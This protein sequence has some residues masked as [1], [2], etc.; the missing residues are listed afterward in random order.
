MIYTKVE[1][2]EIY[3]C[4]KAVSGNKAD[5][6]KRP[7]IVVSGDQLNN[8]YSSQCMV[9]C[10]TTVP[11]K[12]RKSHVPLTSTEAGRFRGSTV[13][14]ERIYTI[15][16]SRLQTY[17]YANER[18]STEEVRLIEEGIKVAMDMDLSL[19]TE[20]ESRL[21]FERDFYKQQYEELLG[22]LI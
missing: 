1:K 12:E 3:W 18:A 13:I 19:E 21:N 9:A 15:E 2:G 16:K 7:V 22:S 14:C 20:T 17:T 5:T 10:L 4:E 8:Q 11:K 6:K